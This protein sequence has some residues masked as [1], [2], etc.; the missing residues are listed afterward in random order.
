MYRQVRTAEHGVGLESAQR[1][2][3]ATAQ[4][5]WHNFVADGDPFLAGDSAAPLCRIHLHR[6]IERARMASADRRRLP[7]SPFDRRTFLSFF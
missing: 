2:L 1:Y 5:N 6:G 3:A 4:L 7:L